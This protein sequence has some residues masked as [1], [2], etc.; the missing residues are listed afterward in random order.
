MPG[1]ARPLRVYS[2]K[3]RRVDGRTRYV[4][5][6]RQVRADLD[7]HLQAVALAPVRA[8]RLIEVTLPRPSS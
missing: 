4:A 6:L 8:G 7:R 1:P 2:R 3:L 5:V